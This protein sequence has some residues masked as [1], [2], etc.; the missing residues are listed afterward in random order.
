[1][2]NLL[3]A[4]PPESVPDVV[5]DEKALRVAAVLAE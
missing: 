1:V 5:T 4:D 2:F 3:G